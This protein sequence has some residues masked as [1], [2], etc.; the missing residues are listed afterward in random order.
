MATR[1]SKRKRGSDAVSPPS[2]S[3]SSARRRGDGAA[4]AAPSHDEPVSLTDVP[5]L[6]GAAWC[7][8]LRQARDDE[9][10]LDVVLKAGDATIRAHKLVLLSHS[11][12]LRGLLTCGL[13]ESSQDEVTVG[14][15][16][17]DGRAVEAIVDCFYTGK[18]ALSSRTVGSVI[19]TANMLGVGQIE[20][21]A[22]AFFIRA[23]EPST[24]ADALVFAAQ[25]TACGEHARELHAGCL[26]YAMEHF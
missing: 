5:A 12:Y 18:I 21:A 11:A 6:A 17:T 8:A 25:Y 9:T 26:R 24:A 20:K 2:E 14:D 19:Q 3:S 15:A 4:A 10:M 16:S 23:L 7:T 22:G 13:A 1:S